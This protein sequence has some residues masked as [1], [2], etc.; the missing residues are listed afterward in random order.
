LRVVFGRRAIKL[1]LERGD[2]NCPQILPEGR[3][4]RKPSAPQAAGRRRLDGL[5]GRR[6]TDSDH[7]VFSGSSRFVR[8]P[9]SSVMTNNAE[10]ADEHGAFDALPSRCQP[11]RVR[12]SPELAEIE[13]KYL[14]IAGRER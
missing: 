4:R 9:D 5:G 1:L 12:H 13:A 11:L 8:R 14:V 10:N 3:Q 7:S 2:V 6:T